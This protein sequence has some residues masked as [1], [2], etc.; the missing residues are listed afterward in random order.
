MFRGTASAQNIVVTLVTQRESTG[1]VRRRRSKIFSKSVTRCRKYAFKRISSNF[2]R[3]SHEISWREGGWGHARSELVI[4]VF[5]PIDG[6]RRRRW[7]DSPS[8]SRRS[9]APRS[10]RCMYFLISFA[11]VSHRTREGRKYYFSV[12]VD[13]A[14]KMM[15]LFSASMQL[16]PAIIRS[17][18]C[19]PWLIL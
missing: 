4:V 15:V 2:Q 18:R 12:S 13:N 17:T 1:Y 11:L 8:P 14:P 19:A 5:L 7:I 3:F 9:L 16:Q 10:F 6:R